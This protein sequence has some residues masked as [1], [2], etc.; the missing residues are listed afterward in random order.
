MTHRRAVCRWVLP[1]SGTRQLTAF[2]V[3]IRTAASRF[4]SGH[5]DRARGRCFRNTNSDFLS[6]SIAPPTVAGFVLERNELP[7]RLRDE[8]GVAVQ[9]AWSRSFVEV[10]GFIRRSTAPAFKVSPD[11]PNP[12]FAAYADLLTP[13]DADFTARGL[14]LVQPDRDAGLQ[15]FADEQFSHARAALVD[16][17]DNQVQARR[18]LH[19]PV[20]A[21]FARVSTRFLS[22]RFTTRRSPA[23]RTDRSR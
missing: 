20:A 16:R 21:L 10:S 8:A 19:P 17:H 3:S 18:Q 4:A 6:A 5:H 13:P 7:D 1:G 22:Q 9:N 15:L 12:V 2:A 23:C 11:D 14:S